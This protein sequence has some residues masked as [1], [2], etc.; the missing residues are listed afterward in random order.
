M[1]TVYE[2]SS[3]SGATAIFLAVLVLS[4]GIPLGLYAVLVRYFSRH[5]LF[6]SGPTIPPFMAAILCT[7]LFGLLFKMMY[8]TA[9]QGFYRVELLDNEVR[10]HSLFPA[11]TV[12]LPRGELAHVERVSA[13]LGLGHLRL[14]TEQGTTYESM[15]TS[16]DAVRESWKG[17]CAYVGCSGSSEHSGGEAE[18]IA[19]ER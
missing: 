10:L 9:L 5:A 1:M 12:T 14:R 13:S 4:L 16:E 8:A 11:R 19:Q 2:L 7:A 3:A 6:H 15:L 18:E 17:L